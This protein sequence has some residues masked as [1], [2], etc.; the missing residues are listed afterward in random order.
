MI[1]GY[2]G[3]E[4]FRDGVRI[5]LRRHAEA[6][7]SADDFW[8][9]LDE[10]SGQDVTAIANAWIKEPGHPLVDITARD[11]GGGLALTLS[12]T[13][14]F[15]DPDAKPTGQRWPVPHIINPGSGHGSR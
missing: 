1:E 8:R 15:S 2:L 12:Q 13:R 7:A 5:Y 9:A 14:Y 10:T 11:E 3:E 6:N 4:T